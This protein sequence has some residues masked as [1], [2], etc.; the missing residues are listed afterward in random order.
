MFYYLAF[1]LK[2]QSEINFPELVQ[3]ESESQADVQIKLDITPSALEGA[4]FNGSDMWISPAKYLYKMAG[5][6]NFYVENGNSV[7]VEPCLN[8][9]GKA[10]RIYLLCNA[11]AA[12]IHQ[13]GSIPLHA[14]GIVIHGKAILIV[15]DSGAG[16]STTIKAIVNRGYKIFTDDVCVLKQLE[17]FVYGIPSYPMMKLW[18]SSIHLLGLGPAILENQIWENISKYGSFFHKDFVIDWVPISIIFI[19][20]KSNE[21]T[22]VELIIPSTLQAFIDVGSNTYRNEYVDSMNLNKIHFDIVSRLVSQCLVYKIV[23]PADGN[24]VK[25]VVELIEQKCNE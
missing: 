16:K 14:S 17:G 13:R 24:T 8:A 21:K 20:E 10:I 5:V 1:G 22:Q 11:M 18:E 23:R 2:I 12:I 7:I 15:G 4:H 9:P 3:T 25:E 19:L 6:A